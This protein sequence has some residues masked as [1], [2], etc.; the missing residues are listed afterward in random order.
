MD[1]KYKIVPKFVFRDVEE[2]GVIL[3]PETDTLYVLSESAKLVW[4]EMISNDNSIT[5]SHIVCILS[6][7]YDG[8]AR[9]IK[10]DVDTFVSKMI[11]SKLFEVIKS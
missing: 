6:E 7:Y 8:D 1:I 2:E 3:L 10:Q 5:H 11:E 4:K 9:E